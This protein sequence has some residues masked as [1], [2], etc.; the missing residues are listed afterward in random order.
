MQKRIHV[1]FE[2]NKISGER[3]FTIIRPFTHHELVQDGSLVE[4]HTQ[5]A[6]VDSSLV[7]ISCTL[8]SVYHPFNQ[9]RERAY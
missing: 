5:C 1:L 9:T 6:A 4:S 8:A 2:R 7:F 3:L